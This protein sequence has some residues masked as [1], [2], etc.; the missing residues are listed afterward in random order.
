MEEEEKEEH[1]GS[2]HAHCNKKT[3]G[4][5]AGVGLV[6]CAK[7]ALALSGPIGWTAMGLIVGVAVITGNELLGED[8]DDD[9]IISVF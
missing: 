6:C 9:D 8:D 3:L 2:S 1:K 5:A 4:V 7:G